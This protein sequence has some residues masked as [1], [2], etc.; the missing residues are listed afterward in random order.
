MTEIELETYLGKKISVK[1]IDGD[2]VEGMCEIF[3]PALGNEP[4]VVE[5]DLKN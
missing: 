2:I 5:I 1:C 4:K 3:T